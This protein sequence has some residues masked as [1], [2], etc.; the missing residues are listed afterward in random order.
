MKQTTPT[1]K[2]QQETG[3]NKWTAAYRPRHA[4][5]EM[6]TGTH[7]DK[8]RSLPENSEW[9]G[10]SGQKTMVYENGLSVVTRN[11]LE[12]RRESSE[13]SSSSGEMAGECRLQGWD[14]G[15]AAPL[16]GFPKSGPCLAG[17]HTNGGAKKIHLLK[18]KCSCQRQTLI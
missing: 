17:R 2:H 13:E 11:G 14:G 15:A 10:V 1:D 6:P 5:E 7:A 18:Y 12:T 3:G 4:C 16:G 8:A 9:E